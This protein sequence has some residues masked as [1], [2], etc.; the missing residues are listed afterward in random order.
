MIGSITSPYLFANEVIMAIIEGFIFLYSYLFISNKRE[1]IQTK[2]FISTLFLISFTLFSFWAT[3]SFPAGYHTILIIL[4][5]S[6]SLALI[7]NV[8]VFLSIVTIVFIGFLMIIIELILFPVFSMVTNTNM[9]ELQT[10][11]EVKLYFSILVKSIELILLFIISKIKSPN[12]KY[13][14]KELSH[15]V[16]IYWV[17]GMFLM[18]MLILSIQFVIYQPEKIIIYE[19]LIILIFL[20]YAIIGYLDYKAKINLIKIEKKYNLQYDYI[21]NL[22][23]LINIIRREKHDFSNHINTIYAMCT[24]NKPN[25]VERI[26]EYLKNITNEIKNSY[27]TFNSGNDY[28]DGLLVV[29]SNYAYENNIIFDVN[30]E[31]MLD[32]VKVDNVDLISIIS[33]ILDNAFEAIILSKQPIERPIISLWTYIEEEKYIISISNNG[34]K[35]D[36]K[37]SEKIFQNGFSTKEK[38]SD[39]HGYGLYIVKKMIEKNDGKITLYSNKVETE[40]QIIFNIIGDSYELYSENF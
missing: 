11:P 26:K 20:I 15:Q 16:I 30:F 34:P 31:S 24:I 2:K 36:D 33:N 14:S 37:I 21:K 39:D 12:I 7:A 6:L 25:T 28:I 4:F 32:K 35:I 27:T 38:N 5:V 17:F 3:L 23:S 18:G 29:K 40:F 10:I 1:I 13:F 19:T 9:E 8:K 22:E